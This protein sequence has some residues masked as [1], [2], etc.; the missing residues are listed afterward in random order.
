MKLKRL[1]IQGFKTFAT[2]TSFDFMDGI[3]CIAGPN[4]S[5]KSNIIDA[6]KWVLGTLSKKNLRAE[7]ILDVLFKGNDYAPQASM[8]SVTL[9]VENDGDLPVDLPEIAI[10]RRTYRDGT[11]ECTMNNTPCGVK[12]IRE[13]F[14]NSGMNSDSFGIIEQGRIEAVVKASPYDRRRFIDDAAGITSFKFKKKE[15]QLKLERFIQEL[16]VIEVQIKENESDLRGLQ[17][18]AGRARNY[19]RMR[20]ELEHKW[21][22]L[23]AHTAACIVPEIHRLNSVKEN[24]EANIARL[25]EEIL[26]TRQKQKELADGVRAKLDE[27]TTIAGCLSTH[28]NEKEN[29]LKNI[30]K[31]Q[32][33]ILE[34]EKTIKN[35]SGKKKELEDTAVA[36]QN[37]IE[38]LGAK[39]AGAKAEV[40]RLK[41]QIAE[42]ETRSAAMRKELQDLEKASEQ[43]KSD[44][45]ELK[46]QAAKIGN[47]IT[48]TRQQIDTC[49]SQL[50]SVRGTIER[51][52]TELKQFK[53][54]RQALILKDQHLGDR[55]HEIAQMVKEL[56]GRRQSVSQEA[57]TVEDTLSRVRQQLFTERASF[58]SW[59]EIEANIQSNISS[60]RALAAKSENVRGLLADL[61]DTANSDLEVVSRVISRFEK[62]IVV[63]TFSTANKLIKSAESL[64]VASFGIVVEEAIDK[65]KP[66]NMVAKVR[67]IDAYRSKYPDENPPLE[68]FINTVFTTGANDYMTVF[69][70]GVLKVGPFLYVSN[71]QAPSESLLAARI[72]LA[73]LKESI[74]RLVETEREVSARHEALASNLSAFETEIKRLRQDGIEIHYQLKSIRDQIDLCTSK[75]ERAEKEIAAYNA[76][77]SRIEAEIGRLENTVRS[78]FAMAERIN[79]EI[80]RCEIQIQGIDGKTAEMKKALAD[81]DTVVS[82]LRMQIVQMDN[83]VSSVMTEIRVLEERLT[84]AKGHCGVYEEQIAAA[85]RHMLEAQTAISDGRKRIEE[86]E[87]RIQEM[88]RRASQLESDKS[89]ADA[90]IER[91]VQQENELSNEYDRILQM[92]RNVDRDI[93]DLNGK[94][95]S[96][97][98]TFEAKFSKDLMQL[99]GTIVLPETIDEKGLTREIE[100]LNRKVQSYGSVNM[101][102]VEMLKQAEEK[103]AFLSKQRDDLVKAKDEVELFIKEVSED[104]S[105]KFEE[106]LGKVRVTFNEIFRK[107]FRGGSANLEVI[108]E[109]GLDPLEWGIEISAK[110]PNKERSKLSLLSGGEQS[111]T[112]C[113]LILSILKLRPKSFCLLDEADHAL[114]E[115]NLVRLLEVIRELASEVQFIIISHNKRTLMIADR[116]YGITQQPPGI[117]KKVAVTISENGEPIFK[118]DSEAESMASTAQG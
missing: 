110:P 48:L 78:K 27:L 73:S 80:A 16:S 116:I 109:E 34:S 56:E 102:A 3:T 93:Q 74:N 9:V 52:A 5:G 51:F 10:S 92:Q 77:A 38:T 60:I 83:Y 104:C 37:Q 66:E 117:T 81:S 98:Q 12:E 28:M 105:R 106:T 101:E 30:E 39:K 111:L 67:C 113:A 20:D 118:K 97:K 11:T 42:V 69:N 100:E 17:I 35:L 85:R 18:Q 64:G 84:D 21:L 26:A 23:A 62:F 15:A 6:V 7:E 32:A 79:H 68:I 59:T 89:S 99:A 72:K 46:S 96:T 107:V 36:L 53:D 43:L 65:N 86:A 108:R 45:V 13:L 14:Y 88:K 49:E 29:L 41:S 57:I 112:A 22:I 76:E 63:D 103:A 47:E 95:E 87:A 19:A 94:L 40:E 71:G 70:A 114:D 8:A 4:G 50:A 82:N 54:E 91:L 115:G 55:L 24:V 44:V 2:R 75:I 61:I 58:D 33:S 90:E 25:R 31:A 1:E